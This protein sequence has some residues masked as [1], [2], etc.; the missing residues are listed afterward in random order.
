MEYNP[1]YLLVQ[2]VKKKLHFLQHRLH[3]K[4]MKVAVYQ[5]NYTQPK[6]VQTYLPIC[7]FCENKLEKYM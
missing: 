4:K 6:G 2:S 3:E 1:D 7:F 5:Q